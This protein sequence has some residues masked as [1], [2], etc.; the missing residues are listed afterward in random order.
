MTQPLS[1]SLFLS[2]S[3]LHTRTHMQMCT[4]C[5][6]AFPLSCLGTGTTTS[7]PLSCSLSCCRE[8]DRA[9]SSPALRPFRAVR[10]VRLH[11]VRFP[12]SRNPGPRLVRVN[13]LG[14]SPPIIYIFLRFRLY[15]ST[16][17]RLVSSAPESQK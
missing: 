3:F 17:S 6:Y 2:I 10:R 16:L 14:P 11:V 4:C 5:A 9:L 1:L 7:Y 13:L 15:A 12:G 8:A